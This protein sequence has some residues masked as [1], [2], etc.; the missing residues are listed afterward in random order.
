MIDLKHNRLCKRYWKLWG[1]VQADPEYARLK[2]ALEA[3]EPE[4][5]AVLAS[6][7]EEAQSTLDR[8]ITIRENMSRRMLEFA[9]E[10][11]T[12]FGGFRP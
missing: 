6:L 5:A 4:Y 12:P 8:Y 3:M 7:P 11:L 10:K 1:R 9:C 2:E